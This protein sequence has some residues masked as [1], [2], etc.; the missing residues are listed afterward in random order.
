MPA[1]GAFILGPSCD[2]SLASDPQDLFERGHA[3]GHQP[4]T[5]VTHGLHARPLGHLEELGFGG[6]GVDQAADFIVRHHQLVHASTALV[7]AH[8]ALLAADRVPATL[9]VLA[10]AMHT[11]LA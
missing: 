2:P 3:L 4:V 10:L 5:V 8:A 7:A 6:L 9:L 1:S 11:Q